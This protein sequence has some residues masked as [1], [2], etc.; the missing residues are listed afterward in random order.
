MYNSSS[1]TWLQRIGAFERY[2]FIEENSYSNFDVHPNDFA[3]Y[4]VLK[5][6]RSQSMNHNINH[7]R[8]TNLPVSCCIS[9]LQAKVGNSNIALICVGLAS[10]PLW[11]TMNLRNFRTL[12]L[13]AH[14]RGFNFIPYFY[15]NLN[16]YS[17]CYKWF[18]RA[19]LLINI[20]SI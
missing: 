12:T 17:K 1:A 11:F 15:N 2:Y 10:I 7:P 13:N 4:R 14:L 5:N 3:P 16:A 8:A 19:R 6:G 20:S 18:S 9:F